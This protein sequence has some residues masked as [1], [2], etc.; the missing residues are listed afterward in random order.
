MTSRTVLLRFTRE[1]NRDN[2]IIE[3]SQEHQN[4]IAKMS[5]KKQTPRRPR[6]NKDLPE[7]PRS[8]TVNRRNIDGNIA[9]REMHNDS[10]EKDSNMEGQYRSPTNSPKKKKQKKKAA[11]NEEKHQE[12]NRVLERNQ[13]LTKFTEV[14]ARG[15]AFCRNNQTEM[16]PPTKT[17]IIKEKKSCM[18][19]FS[20]MNITGKFEAT[21]V[22][23]DRFCQ[24]QL[25]SRKSSIL[26]VCINHSSSIWGVNPR[27]AGSPPH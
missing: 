17:V 13:Q 5:P 8:S 1:G 26:T 14:T 7:T 22:I 18:H 2:D 11:P 3:K 9:F 27:V 19:V 25:K 4:H 24:T 20:K 12:K 15:E 21:N 16:I 23:Q 10:Q 6:S